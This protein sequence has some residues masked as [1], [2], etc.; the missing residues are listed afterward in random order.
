MAAIQVMGLGSLENRL[1]VFQ[2]KGLA[3]DEPAPCPPEEP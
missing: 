2:G 3:G 1:S